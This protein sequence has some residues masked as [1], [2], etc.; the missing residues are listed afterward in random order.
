[1][2]ILILSIFDTYQDAYFN[3]SSLFIKFLHM[4]V[5]PDVVPAFIAG[6][7]FMAVALSET[8]GSTECT[9]ILNMIFH[10]NHTWPFL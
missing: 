4:S 5:L 2:I 1:M 8:P 7:T 6:V 9:E 3:L 10:T